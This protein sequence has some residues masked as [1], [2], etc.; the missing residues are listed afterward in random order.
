MDSAEFEIEETSLINESSSDFGSLGALASAWREED[1]LSEEQALEV[2][3]EWLGRTRHRPG[4]L[5]RTMP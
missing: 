4:G 5:I 3:Y 2:F 1:P